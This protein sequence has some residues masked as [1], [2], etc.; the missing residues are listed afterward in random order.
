MHLLI[1]L[2]QISLQ[3]RNI[4]AYT[5]LTFVDYDTLPIYF[6]LYKNYFYKTIEA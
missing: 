2:H 3:A 4:Q 6:V 1:T 5:N